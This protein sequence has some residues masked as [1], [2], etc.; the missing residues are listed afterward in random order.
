MVII[1]GPEN[2]FFAFFFLT[3]MKY[4]LNG[5]PSNYRSQDL[6]HLNIKFYIYEILIDT[7]VFGY[8]WAWSSVSGVGSRMTFAGLRS[9]RYIPRWSAAVE[10]P[11]E[12]LKCRNKDSVHLDLKKKKL[13]KRKIPFSYHISCT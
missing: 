4:K 10:V 12:I 9:Y 1:I 8:T 7:A 13:N 3:S 6:F 2:F 5:M 11:T